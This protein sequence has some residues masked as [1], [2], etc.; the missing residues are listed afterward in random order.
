MSR[1]ASVETFIVTIPRDTPYLGPLAPG[2]SVNSRGYVVRRGNGTI[3]PTVDRS[4]VVKVTCDDGS[5]G[6]GETYGI[7]APRATCEIVND[8][9]APV[10]IGA[11]PADVEQVWDELYGLMRVRGCSG[12]FHVDAIAAIDIA[13][14]DLYGKQRGMPIRDLLGPTVN[15]TVPGYLSGLPAATL[16]ERVSLAKE[17]YAAGHRAFKFAA[18]VSHEGIVAEMAALRAALGPDA[19]I[20]VDLHWKFTAD[21]ALELI[22]ALE[23][24]RPFFVEAPVKPEDQV[25]LARV[26]RESRIAVAAGEEWYTAYEAANRLAAG[27]LAI[28]QPEMGHTGITQFRRIA[29]LAAERGATIAPHATIG[30]GLFLAASLQVSATLRPL[31]KHEWQHSVFERNL[32]LLDSDM[33]YADGAY[34]LPTAPGL[35]A[36]PNARLWDFA[37]RIAG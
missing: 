16:E 22:A 15:A 6:W 32:Q 31:W 27:P 21:E 30:T 8:L 23:P 17:K 19:Q 13:L 36:A 33:G 37:E 2:E 26:A 28:L 7:C 35:G 29:A 5:V 10:A 9:L 12:G 1:V 11:N 3:Y 18:V 20:M 24:H 25:G 4:I 14:W 34:L